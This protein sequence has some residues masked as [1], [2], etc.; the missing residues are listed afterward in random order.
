MP[1][2]CNARPD[3]N[4]PFKDVNS[5]SY[6]GDVCV[7]DRNSGGSV[8]CHRDAQRK[9]EG[10]PAFGLSLSTDGLGQISCTILPIADAMLLLQGRS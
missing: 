10:Q 4:V 1:G 7:V 6:E 8:E 3:T 5:L 2:C 9:S